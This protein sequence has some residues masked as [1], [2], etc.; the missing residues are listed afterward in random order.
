MTP[1]ASS[2]PA[3]N[4]TTFLAAIVIFSLVAGLIPSRAGRSLIEN[5]PKPRIATLSPSLRAPEMASSTASSAFLESA[6]L[7]PWAAMAFTRSVLFILCKI[8]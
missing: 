7:K 5:V 1:A 3:L 4:L 6:L 8:I 2:A